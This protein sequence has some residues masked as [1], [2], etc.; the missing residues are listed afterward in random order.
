VV[1][2]VSEESGQISLAVGGKLEA[3]P[4]ENL[5]RRL[6]RLMNASMVPMKSGKRAA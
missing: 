5:S 1:L 2:V 4:R 3:V 6:A